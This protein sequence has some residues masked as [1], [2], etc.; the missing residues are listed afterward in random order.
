[1]PLTSLHAY[2]VPA[3]SARPSKRQAINDRLIDVIRCFP[4]GVFRSVLHP[5]IEL[6]DTNRA[7]MEQTTVGPVGCTRWVSTT[8]PAWAELFVPGGTFT[9]TVTVFALCAKTGSGTDQ[10]HVFK[11]GDVSNAHFGVEVPLGHTTVAGNCWTTGTETATTSSFPA[12]SQN[13]IFTVAVH[14]SPFSTDTGMLQSYLNGTNEGNYTGYQPNVP[15]TTF[16]P[17]IYIGAIQ[18][19]AV[20]PPIKVAMVAI[21]HR[22]VFNWELSMLA[23]DPYMIFRDPAPSLEYPLRPIEDVHGCAEITHDSASA[24]VTTETC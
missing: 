2:D 13:D 11:I 22:R 20:E 3:I 6:V 1:M 12:L 4:D 10:T 8:D 21:W 5:G 23:A 18:G 19:S 7:D 24:E 14:R 9:Q 16:D 15:A 17:K